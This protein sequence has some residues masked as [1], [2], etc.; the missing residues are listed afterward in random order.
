VSELRRQLLSRARSLADL[1]SERS[2]AEL[3]CAVVWLEL[4]ARTHACA[5]VLERIAIHYLLLAEHPDVRAQ[6][7]LAER[8][9]S[10]A[11]H[12]TDQAELG[13]PPLSGFLERAR[14]DA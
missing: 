1:A 3:L 8:Y 7:G 9:A 12:W 5:G 6:A 13:A 10:R 14:A 2:E 4:R 11:W